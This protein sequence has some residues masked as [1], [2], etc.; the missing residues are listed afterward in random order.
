M[1][2]YPAFNN[3]YWWKLFCW[4]GIFEPSPVNGEFKWYLGH[5]LW[6]VPKIFDAQNKVCVATN[7]LWQFQRNLWINSQLMIA[8]DDIILHFSFQYLFQNILQ[9]KCWIVPT[10]L[11]KFHE[12]TLS[13]NAQYHRVILT[14]IILELFW[15]ISILLHHIWTPC[16][17]NQCHKIK[18]RASYP[19]LYFVE[20]KLLIPDM[21]TD[22][23]TQVVAYLCKT[24]TSG[25]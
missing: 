1:T 10:L 4:C 18:N 9:M 3:F 21:K 2:R 20:C 19:L 5:I 25:F 15:K 7:K 14:L 6:I 16:H 17:I 22:N 11:E 8:V 13:G 12:L 23:D 24:I